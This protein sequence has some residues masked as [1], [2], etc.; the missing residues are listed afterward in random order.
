MLLTLNLVVV[1]TML[2]F[3]LIF[4]C[5]M[6]SLRRVF[7]FFNLEQLGGP[8]AKNPIRAYARILYTFRDQNIHVSWRMVEEHMKVL[9]SASVSQTFYIEILI[10]HFGR[11]ICNA[12]KRFL[13]GVFIFLFRRKHNS[14]SLNGFRPSF[15]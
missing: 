4:F 11:K 9:L 13:C 8:A 3:V 2:L 1:R 14:L 12:L 10:S 15:P 5:S 7:F 6:D